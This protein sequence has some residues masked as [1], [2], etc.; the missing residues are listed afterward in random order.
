MLENKFSDLNCSGVA[1]LINAI[2]LKKEM[3][4]D[5][6]RRSKSQLNKRSLES[7]P[8]DNE[9]YAKGDLAVQYDNVKPRYMSPSK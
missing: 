5:K 1:D 3:S 9:Q 4:L 7:K 8:A 6:S 2:R